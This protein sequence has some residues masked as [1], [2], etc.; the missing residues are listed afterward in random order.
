M[1][2]SP[3]PSEIPS[4]SAAQETDTTTGT[5]SR[6]PETK[7]AVAEANA[8]IAGENPAVDPQTEG[9]SEAGEN[10]A[11][12][13]EAIE[14]T[15]LAAKSPLVAAA[16]K[17][18]AAPRSSKYQGVTRLKWS[19]KYEAHLWDNIH[20]APGR[21]RKGRHIYLGSYDNEDKAARAHDL[22][23]LKFWGPSSEAKLNFPVI[24]NT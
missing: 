13:S 23:V 12:D 4:D 5:P 7:Q 16:I 20:C 9:T 24:Q 3:N 10:V 15:P 1:H 19:G 2:G 22:A 18:H 8:E 6:D 17:K 11:K 21:K 14:V